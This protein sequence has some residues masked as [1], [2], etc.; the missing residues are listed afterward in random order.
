MI[1]I[2]FLSIVQGI[3]EFLPISS[4]AHLIL[5]S[6]QFNFDNK[7]LTIDLSLHLGSLLA[8]LL[9]FKKDFIN[10]LLNKSLLL[11]IILGSAPTILVGIILI[12]LNIIDYLRNAKIIAFN[13]IFFG[14][15]LYFSDK[16]KSIKS[17]NNEFSIKSSVYIGLMQILSLIPGV[18][19]SGI[20]ITGARFLNFGRLDAAKISFLLSI[21]TLFA[22]SAYNILK[23]TS[24]KNLEISYQNYWSIILSFLFS[25]ITLKVF[26]NFLKNF[27]LVFF[28]FY[29]I[30]LGLIILS[31]I[32]L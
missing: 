12:K 2:L 5:I 3:T 7:D 8:V 15:L 20:T 22:V 6:N 10:F 25:Y 18:S 4:S 13:T 24:L 23:I 11:K 21:P 32:Y 9:F 28:V 14:I 26:F 29:R 17:F 16:S 19:R 31:F 1:E 27:S 30:L